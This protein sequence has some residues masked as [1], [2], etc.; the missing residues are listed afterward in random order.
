MYIYVE[1]SVYQALLTYLTQLGIDPSLYL[2]QDADGYYVDYIPL[3]DDG[4][5][6]E[7]DGAIWTISLR[8][9]Q[10]GIFIGNT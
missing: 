8:P 1:Q 3:V 4:Y 5:A 9:S 7:Q 10:K 2:G 6:I